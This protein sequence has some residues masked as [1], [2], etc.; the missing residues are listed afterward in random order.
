MELSH[1]Q[2]KS[3]SFPFPYPPPPSDQKLTPLQ[4]FSRPTTLL[5]HDP[6]SSLREGDIITITS[7]WRA[8][9]HVHHVVSSIIAPFGEP[10]EARP[11]VPSEE[12]RIAEREARYRAKEERRGRRSAERDGV[13]GER[14]VSEDEVLDGVQ[15]AREEEGEVKGVRV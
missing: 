7:G 9:K 15:E 2:G 1:P 11:A 10:I 3:P 4:K 5:V 6:R 14:L 12:E 13:V 8:S